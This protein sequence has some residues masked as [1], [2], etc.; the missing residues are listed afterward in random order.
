VL[1]PVFK[2]TY[3]RRFPPGAG[4]NVYRDRVIQQFKDLG[5]SLDWVETRPDLRADRIGYYGL[6][7]GAR[8]GIVNAALEP[9]LRAIVLV[10]GGLS[11]GP[12]P[13]EIDP[14]NFAPHVE[15]P[16]LLV[17]GRDDFRRPLKQSQEPLMRLL[18]SKEKRHYVF[19]GGH[20]PPRWQEVIKETLDWFDRYL[21]PV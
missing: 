3:E 4:P 1:L 6:S 8:T 12:E 10:S 2:G 18:G 14:F 17:G 11:T 15:A 16:V 21:G 7:M 5:R 13:G 19:E 20:V 9:R